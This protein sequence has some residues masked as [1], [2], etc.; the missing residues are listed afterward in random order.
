M[1]TQEN[2]E[3]NLTILWIGRAII[4]AAFIFCL[5]A[6]MILFNR[7]WNRV[8]DYRRASDIQAIQNAL[9]LYNSQLGTY[10]ATQVDLDGWDT[11]LDASGNGFL[12]EIKDKGWL[13]LN[14]FDPKNDAS[15]YYRYRYFPAGSFGCTKPFAVFQ[16]MQFEL[17]GIPGKGA[18]PAKDFTQEAPLGFTLKVDG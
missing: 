1:L 18:C 13:S 8:R 11:S 7:H 5:V 10:P 12:K 14:P 2:G 4:V 9:N 16:V 3:V 17:P 15:H 6:I